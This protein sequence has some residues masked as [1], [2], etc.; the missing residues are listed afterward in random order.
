M[1]KYLTITLLF[2]ATFCKAQTPS[3][4]L[5]LLAV[6]SAF[7]NL[8]TSF[9]LAQVAMSGYYE[10]LLH[11]PSISINGTSHS[12]TDGQSWTISTTVPAITVL[13]PK[14]SNYTV[15]TSDFGTA[16]VLYV[17]VDCTSGAVTITEPTASSITGYTIIIAKT[18]ATSNMVTISGLATDNKMNIQNSSKETFSDGTAIRQN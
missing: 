14:T 17:P 4:H 18:D 3:P 6:D 7:N 10:N 5:K 12:V 8:I 1:K 16:K 11:I 15:T 9:Y 2:F 13:A